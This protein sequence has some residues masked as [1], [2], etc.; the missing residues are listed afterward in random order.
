[1]VSKW[2]LHRWHLT[3]SHT[4]KQ[5]LLPGLAEKSKA[6]RKVDARRHCALS[7]FLGGAAHV[8]INQGQHSRSCASILPGNNFHDYCT[9]PTTLLTGRLALRKKVQSGKGRS[10]PA[11]PFPYLFPS[12][13]STWCIRDV[14][15]D[16]A[17]PEPHR[18]YRSRICS[19]CP[20][21]DR[22]PITRVPTPA[23]FAS[24]ATTT[25]SASPSSAKP[26]PIAVRATASCRS[27]AVS[28]TRIITSPSTRTST[29]YAAISR[30]SSRI[31]SACLSC[32]M[33][34]STS[35]L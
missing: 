29:G 16:T 30:P 26:K 9:T 31:I 28:L 13:P 8:F 15:C 11:H 20:I 2:Y 33:C 12:Y 5:L 10:H 14:A 17:P 7:R 18:S 24:A 6:S 4:C 21:K 35:P 25:E 19:T 32:G 3:C 1:M 23:G 34:A 27:T 22:A